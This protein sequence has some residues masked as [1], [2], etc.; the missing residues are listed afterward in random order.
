[1]TGAVY[2]YRCGTCGS[3]SLVLS[4]RANGGWQVHCMDGHEMVSVPGI[5]ILIAGPAIVAD[6]GFEPT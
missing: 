4:G 1:M 5:Q 6:V 3:A 2:P